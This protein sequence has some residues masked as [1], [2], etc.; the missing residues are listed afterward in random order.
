MALCKPSDQYLNQLRK[1]YRK[2]TKKQR[3]RILDEFVETT[4]YHRKHAVALLRGKRQHR[5]RHVPIRRPH[6]RIY[7]DEDKRA[8]FGLADLFDA[9]GSKRLRAAMDGELST[10]YQ[11]P[12][13]Q[14]CRACFERLQG[15]SPATMD[16]LRRAQRR[17]PGRRRGGTK[18]GA[19][20]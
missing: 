19:L 3:G 16:R 7:T 15:F 14:V 9:R 5:N 20:L 4:G 12:S 18:P 1:R 10:L 6:Q 2:A 11:R 17:A 13:V 8:V